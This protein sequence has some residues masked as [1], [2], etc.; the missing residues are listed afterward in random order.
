MPVELSRKEAREAAAACRGQE[1]LYRKQA[2]SVGVGE[3]RTILEDAAARMAKL[4]EKFET[5]AE[6]PAGPGRQRAASCGA[7][8]LGQS[9]AAQDLSRGQA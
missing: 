9:V 8:S 3:T 5:H 2:Q 4:A 6:R 7:T 1:Y